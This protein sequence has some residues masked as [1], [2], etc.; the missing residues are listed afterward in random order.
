MGLPATE[1]HQPLYLKQAC[2]SLRS[3]QLLDKQSTVFNQVL[4][5]PY[6]KEQNIQL[7]SL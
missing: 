6:L 1:A 3:F 4:I 2:E 5:H 7:V